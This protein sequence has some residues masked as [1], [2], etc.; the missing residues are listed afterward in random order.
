MGLVISISRQFKPSSQEEFEEFKQVGSI[1][2]LKAIRTHNPDKACLS[3]WAY[4]YIT[5]AIMRYLDN[6]KTGIQTISIEDV[7]IVPPKTTSCESLDEF[8]P[9]SLTSEEK[10]VLKLRC[11]DND[12][13]EIATQLNTTPYFIGKIIQ[14]AVA[15]IRDANK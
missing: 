7:H 9:D 6:K 10:A 14:S 2:L 1:G 11:E 4:Q 5:W 15:K 12:I 3:T 13:K 8:M